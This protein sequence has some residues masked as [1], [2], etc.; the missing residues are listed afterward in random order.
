MFGAVGGAT[1]G[2]VETGRQGIANLL[3]TR[4]GLDPGEIRDAAAVGS[5]VP[6][7]GKLLK[8]VSKLAPVRAVGGF[9][10][11][12]IKPSASKS[13]R[14]MGKIATAAK[15]DEGSLKRLTDDYLQRYP[16]ASKVEDKV[17]QDIKGVF[18]KKR[19]LGNKPFDLLSR[20][21]AVVRDNIKRA[22]NLVEL[23]MDLLQ[24]GKKPSTQALAKLRWEHKILTES[25]NNFN[26]HV[27]DIRT[28]R[29]GQSDI[30]R[31]LTEMALRKGSDIVQNPQRALEK[32]G[33]I[34]KLSNLTGVGFQPAPNLSLIH[35]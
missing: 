20:D 10:A 21:P 25:E 28:P 4:D 29:T 9:L 3:G 32:P 15:L 8:G 5:I 13:A 1:E 30:P 26:K 22:K 6:G 16:K 24:K 7:G 23:E 12:I 31:G 14:A 27:R 17:L 18:Q 34:E 11:D 33:I 35:I 19:T 2:A